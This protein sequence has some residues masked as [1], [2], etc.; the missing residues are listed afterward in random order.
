MVTVHAEPAD[1]SSVV[2]S[3]DAG[4]W[5]RE[6]HGPAANLTIPA[7]FV[8]AALSGAA[9]ALLEPGPGKWRVTIS[10]IQFLVV[11]TTPDDVQNAAFAAV[12]GAI[13]P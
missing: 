4:R 11:D 5:Q 9:R 7:D 3:E 8:E 1:E 13:R 6:V 2:L 12:S 10:E